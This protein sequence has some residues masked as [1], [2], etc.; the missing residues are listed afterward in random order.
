MQFPKPTVNLAEIR[1]KYHQAADDEKS[2]R[3]KKH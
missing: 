3:S 2:G 1:R